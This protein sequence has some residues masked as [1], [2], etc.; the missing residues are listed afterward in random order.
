MTV[1]LYSAGASHATSLVASGDY[2]NTA[3]WSFS[4]E[5]GDKLLG[6]NGDDWSNYAKWHMGTDSEANDKTKEKYKYPYGKDGKVYG[7]ALR[8][9]RSRAAQNDATA[10]FDKAGELLD[11]IKKKEGDSSS[12]QSG[13]NVRAQ[14]YPDYDPDGDGDNDAEEAASYISSACLLLSSAMSCL[15]GDMDSGDSSN[16]NMPNMPGMQRRVPAQ[17][18]SS[19]VNFKATNV[20]SILRVNASSK[21]DVAQMDLFGV[22]GGDFWGDGGITKEQFA[23]M[24]NKIPSSA[25][26]VDMRMSS[27]GGDVFDGRAIANMMKD[28]PCAFDVNIIAEASSIASIIAIAGGDTV[29]MGDGAVMLVHRCY[30]FTVGNSQE[31]TK[32]AQDLDTIDKTM[33][34]TYARKTGMKPEA[35]MSL[36]DENR[37]MDAEEA[38]RLGFADTITNYGNTNASS[39]LQ[40]AA[41]NVDRSKFHL[42]PLPD[43]KKD[44]PNMEAAR[45]AIARIAAKVK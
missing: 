15:T 23:Q 34:Q 33:V 3:P 45:A 42:P 31:L 21:P 5:D 41:M 24:L 27:P 17:A 9:I 6:P 14:N 39:L 4:S 13:N 1:S 10:I 18:K 20:K 44:K 38:K 22:V 30:A 29:H 7:S 8:A 40:I 12:A 36:M 16:S 25:K 19:V 35:I 11:S 2:D 43:A 37:Y 32:L 26:R 28:H